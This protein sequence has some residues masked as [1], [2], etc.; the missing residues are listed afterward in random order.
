MKY[1][2]PGP[3]SKPKY[4]RLEEFILQAITRGDYPLHS[5]LP[6][7]NELCRDSG[8]SRDTVLAAYGKL[9]ERGI[10]RAIH[11]SGFFVAKNSFDHKLPLFLLFDVMNGYKEVLFR[12]F[13]EN[14]SKHYAVDIYFH[15]YNTQVL[16]N[17]VRLN[18]GHYEKY[19]VMPHFHENI[20]S[21]LDKI[22]PDKL[23][24]L[25]NIVIGM[26]VP[27]VFQNFE[28]DMYQA[29]SEAAPLLNRYKKLVFLDN[30]LF[31]FIPEGMKTGFLSYCRVNRFPHRMAPEFRENEME[32]GD[33]YIA[34]SD[35]DL[36]N[37]IKSAGRKG[38]KPGMD[39]GLISY[40]E[41]PLKEVLA[42]GITVI[43]TNFEKMGQLA[44]DCIL[45][46]RHEII[47]NE[48]RLILRNSL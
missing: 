46:E 26:N 5:R 41:T 2:L 6:S 19:V 31:Q 3:A 13:M 14:I 32:K 45:H 33:V 16:K 47:A 4:L 44:A 36:I 30:T 40:D 24:F 15:Y 12:S 28:Q 18:A 10:I 37:I 21:F 48:C 7:I 11:G 23:F 9:Q 25:D 8:L 20:A 39:F 29:L 43:S 17:L 35:A 38:L 27:A 42:G 1:R 34:V 22:P